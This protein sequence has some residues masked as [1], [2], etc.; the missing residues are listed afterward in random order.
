MVIDAFLKQLDAMFAS[1]DTPRPASD[2]KDDHSVCNWLTYK[3]ICASY[4]SPTAGSSTRPSQSSH[5]VT[6]PSHLETQLS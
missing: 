4:T 2:A 3:D 5:H 1:K 6:S